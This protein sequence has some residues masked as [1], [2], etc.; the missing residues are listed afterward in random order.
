[1][2]S[3]SFQESDNK[4][5][6]NLAPLRTHPRGPGGPMGPPYG[7][8]VGGDL[9]TFDVEAPR[10]HRCR[11]VVTSIFQRPQ[12]VHEKCF[13]TGLFDVVQFDR[14]KGNSINTHNTELII[15]AFLHPNPK[16]VANKLNAQTFIKYNSLQVNNQ[17]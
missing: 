1:M 4:I 9:F 14:N 12:R 5:P 2:R 6:V 3:Q 13:V 10:I 7:R 8:R 16:L 11:H 15:Y 17:Y